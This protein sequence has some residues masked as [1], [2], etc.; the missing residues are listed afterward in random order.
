LSKP[1]ADTG[2]RSGETPSV[3]LL[4][5]KNKK[6]TLRLPCRKVYVM[7][8][9]FPYLVV[10]ESLKATVG[11][12][13]LD[14][15]IYRRNGSDEDSGPWFD[16]LCRHFQG[17]GFISPG[18]VGMYA[19]V[20]RAAVHKRLYEGKMT[21]FSFHVVEAKR[22]L[23]GYQK[24][25]KQRPY[26]YVPV[27]ECKA[28]AEE[29]KARPDRKAAYAEAAGGDKP[30][31]GGDFL[32]KATKDEGNK[33][34]KYDESLPRNDLASLVKLLVDEAIDKA[35]PAG[36]RRARVQKRADKQRNG[37][38]VA[39]TARMAKEIKQKREK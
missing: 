35:L 1:D 13:D 22:S 10:P 31:W 8:T 3:A 37:I 18:G 19:P 38:Q 21:A 39:R 15:R 30:D 16:A 6:L 2:T 24:K 36:M 34:V 9:N 32:D 5:P 4:S 26:L 20:S 14:T 23:F 28:W 7:E 29:L 11:E 17:E 25:L 33:A 12:P 27:S